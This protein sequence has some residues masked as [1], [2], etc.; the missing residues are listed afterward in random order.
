MEL[1]AVHA[2]FCWPE[3]MNPAA[4]LVIVT[5]GGVPSA[6]E[7]SVLPVGSSTAML[8]VPAVKG[9]NSLK[10]GS[11]WKSDP[12]VSV[13]PVVGVKFRVYKTAPPAPNSCIE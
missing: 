7:M 12:M 6:T 8:A 9:M 2:M 1:A 11:V 4:G 5:V 3:P 10:I 13:V